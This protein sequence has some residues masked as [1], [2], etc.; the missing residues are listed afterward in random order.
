M[1]EHNHQGSGTGK[2]S[3]ARHVNPQL[4]YMRECEARDWLR[5]GYNNRVRIEELKKAIASKRG[6]AA[7]EQL[8]E[9]MRRQWRRRAEW[10]E[11][12]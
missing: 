8:I 6:P 10:M 2:G 7:A 3:T 12:A 1:Q 4:Q 9:E 11:G 5:R